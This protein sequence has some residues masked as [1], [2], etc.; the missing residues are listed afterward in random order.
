[1]NILVTV[2]DNYMYPLKIMIGSLFQHN[3]EEKVTVYLLHSD[4]SEKNRK[5]LARM[6]SYYGGTFVPVRVPEELFAEAPCPAYFSREMYYRI[7]APWL[8]PELDRVLYLDPDMIVLRDLSKFYNMDLNG[9]CYAGCK[10]RYGYSRLE[11]RDPEKWSDHI[12]INSGVLLCNLRE[13]RF[14]TTREEYLEYIEAHKDTLEYPDQD[15]INFMN[16]NRIRYADEMYNLDPN[17]LHAWEYIAM[18]VKPLNFLCRPFIL[19]Y[20]GGDKPWVHTYNRLGLNWYVQ[21]E[22]KINPHI[23]DTRKQELA[24]GRMRDLRHLA[25]FGKCVIH[26]IKRKVLKMDDVFM[27]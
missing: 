7:L 3:K 23:K 4:V 27:E 2:N 19:H 20:M 25:Y 22:K 21:E 16:Y 10:D 12:Y 13:L 14:V 26:R 18:M 17:N 15:V 11:R 8:L 24:K 9:F 6:I 1:M 5:T